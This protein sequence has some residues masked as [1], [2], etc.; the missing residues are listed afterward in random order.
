MKRGKINIRKLIG[1]FCCCVC[2]WFQIIFQNCAVF[3]LLTVIGSE[4]CDCCSIAAYW[5]YEFENMTVA[6]VLIRGWIQPEEFRYQNG[7]GVFYRDYSL[8]SKRFWSQEQHWS[9]LNPQLVRG[10]KEGQ[11]VVSAFN[12]LWKFHTLP[13]TKKKLQFAIK[14]DF[15][16][17]FVVYNCR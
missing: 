10:Q 1:L 9:P 14:C 5:N 16:W 2:D 6:L 8:R 17:F 7:V 4:Y 11:R 13:L 12:I 15:E 3:Y